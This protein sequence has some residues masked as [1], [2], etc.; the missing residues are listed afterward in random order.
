MNQMMNGIGKMLYQARIL[1][2]ALYIGLALIIGLLIYKFFIEVA[3][4][5]G[6]ILFENVPKIDLIIKTLEIVDMVMVVQLVWVV[7]LAG[8]SLFVTD[9]NFREDASNKPDWLSHVT[10]YNLKL[11]LAFAIISISGVHALKVYLEGQADTATML[12]TIAV[13]LVFVLSAIGIAGAERMTKDRRSGG[14]S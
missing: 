11:K 7:A 3:K 5:A 4:L 6:T 2:S 12:V 14:H 10:T 13:H 8:F 9:E 1:M